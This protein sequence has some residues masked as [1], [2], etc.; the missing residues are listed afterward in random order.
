MRRMVSRVGDNHQIFP[1]DGHRVAF[2]GRGVNVYSVNL[3]TYWMHQLATA[4]KRLTPAVKARKL[5]V[6][7][8]GAILSACFQFQER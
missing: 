1:E 4:T 8:R 5:R 6:C 7:G 2:A 3:L